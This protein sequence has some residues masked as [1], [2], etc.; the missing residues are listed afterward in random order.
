MLNNQRVNF[1]TLKPVIW[2]M[3]NSTE[4]DSPSLAVGQLPDC[5]WMCFSAENVVPT[6]ATFRFTIDN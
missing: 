6:G 4:V 5:L 1:T 3:G 2:S